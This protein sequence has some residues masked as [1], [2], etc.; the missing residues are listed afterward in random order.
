MS[1]LPRLHPSSRWAA[2]IAIATASAQ[3]ACATETPV[4]GPRTV[5][6]ETTTGSTA[7]GAA[8]IRAAGVVT[9]RHDQ[10]DRDRITLVMQEA[11][12]AWWVIVP[13][14]QCTAGG[15]GFSDVPADLGPGHRV[16]VDGTR[17]RSSFAPQLRATA[18]AVTGTASLPDARSA[19]E[20]GFF[21]G[22]GGA[23]RTTV[24]G[25]VQSVRSDKGVWTLALDVEGRRVTVRS[26]QAPDAEVASQLVDAPVRITGVAGAVRNIRGQFL[27]PV[28]VVNSLAE[29]VRVAG[30][31][32]TAFDAPFVRLADIARFGTETL[33]GH[34]FQTEGT[35]T[36]SLP[37]R[38]LYLEDE[39]LGIRVET[40]DKEVYAPGDRVRVA[41]FL[42]TGRQLRG[43]TG[44]VTRRVGRRPAPTPIVTTPT[45]ITG[46]DQPRR[47]GSPERTRNDF[48]GRLVTFTATVADAGPTRDGGVLRLAGDGTILEATLLPEAY[49]AAVHFR[50]GSEISLTGIVQY[51]VARQQEELIDG[52]LSSFDRFSLLVHDAAD[53][54]VLRA[55][56]WW[57]PFRLTA[58]L[59]AVLAV[60]AAALA[61]AWSLRR[62]VALQ[63]AAI[64]KEMRARREAAVE[65]QATLRERTRLAANL[66]DTLLQSMAGIGFQLEA[67]QMSTRRSSAADTEE[68]ADHLDVARRMVDHAVDDIRGSVWALRSTA[69]HGRSLTEAIEALVVRVGAGHRARIDLQTTGDSFELPDFVTGNLLLIV[70]EAVFNAIRHGDPDLIHIRVSFHT[71]DATVELSIHDDG[72]GFEVGRQRGPDEGHFGLQGMRERAERLGGRLAVESAP[73]RG[74]VVRCRVRCREYDPEMERDDAGPLVDSKQSA[75]VP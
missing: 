52:R 51:D 30:P 8:G 33:S 36:R 10:P 21:R 15:G 42:D 7:S 32:S 45:T 60:L 39:G 23:I 28:L 64:A 62:Q 27:G 49:D 40:G 58:A 63:A 22:A 4:A 3:V 65:F 41:G 12:E 68:A 1:L 56:A 48:A 73:A 75:E 37:T 6:I 72:R 59:A 38:Y 11:D 31:S 46:G 53:L 47:R 70:Q 24:A 13:Y 54:R 44:A 35:V 57:T 17:D 19:E 66:H 18:L 61:W 16:V 67:C 5:L 43:M 14:R 69:V 50:P 71:D 2:A 9:F 34:R 25:I 55:A 26:G 20:S 29:A 74:T